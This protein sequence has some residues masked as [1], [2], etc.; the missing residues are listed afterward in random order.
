ME[1]GA[2][3]RLLP[4]KICMLHRL[5]RFDFFHNGLIRLDNCIQYTFNYLEDLKG[6]F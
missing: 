4:K 1:I 5:D 2:K 6:H 3:K